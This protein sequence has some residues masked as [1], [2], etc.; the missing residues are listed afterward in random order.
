MVLNH[1]RKGLDESVSHAFRLQSHFVAMRGDWSTSDVSGVIF[2]DNQS[3]RFMEHLLFRWIG[4]SSRDDLI[5]RSPVCLYVDSWL[6]SRSIEFSTSPWF[7]GIQGIGLGL[8]ERMDPFLLG[9][10]LKYGVTSARLCTFIARHLLVCFT[11]YTRVGLR[12]AR[13]TLFPVRTHVRQPVPRFDSI[14]ACQRCE[15]LPLMLPLSQH[16]PFISVQA[17][18]CRACR[19]VPMGFFVV[20]V[21]SLV[22]PFSVFDICCS[23]SACFRTLTTLTVIIFLRLIPRLVLQCRPAVLFLRPSDICS[24]ISYVVGAVD[25]LSFVALLDSARPPSRHT[26]SW[27]RHTIFVLR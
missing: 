18:R 21:G 16:L 17:F 25:E 9:S 13:C 24:T 5:G 7:S 8:W 27:F 19:Q 26:S 15:C 1:E 6:S 11:R 14:A 3:V 22:G 23:Q 10:L 12:S 4:R 20:I 2:S